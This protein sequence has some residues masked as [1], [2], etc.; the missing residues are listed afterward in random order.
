MTTRTKPDVVVWAVVD[1]KGR[2]RST[3]TGCTKREAQ[4]SA[5]DLDYYEASRA[6]HRVVRCVGTLPAKR[7]RVARAPRVTASRDY[8]SED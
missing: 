3:D 5:E 2:I 8:R 4:V 6:P 1:A 7:G